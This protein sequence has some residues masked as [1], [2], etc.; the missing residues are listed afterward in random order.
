M[1]LSTESESEQNTFGFRNGPPAMSKTL[2]TSLLNLVFILFLYYANQTST[3]TITKFSMIRVNPAPLADFSLD[4]DAGC[5]P[6]FAQFTDL[7]I[8]Q[9]GTIK[10]WFWA[11]GNGESST[12]ANPSVVYTGIK[13]Y[14]VYLKI[15]DANNCEATVS[16]SSFIKLDGPT[17]DFSVTDS[18]AC[19][20]P[21]PITFVNQSIGN[22]IEYYWDFGDGTN[23]TG[24]IPGTHY[25]NSFDSITAFLAVTEKKT[26][27]SDTLSKGLVVGNYEAEFDWNIV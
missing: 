24:D 6:H 26:G 20:L 12:E 11:F 22:D 13:D 27:C 16:K 25:Y 18:I 19:G 9:A 3:D 21:S 15:I 1:D 7:S 8:P 4:D 2:Q 10:E 14:D 5:S 23:S 17:A